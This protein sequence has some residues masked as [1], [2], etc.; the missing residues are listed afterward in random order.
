MKSHTNTRPRMKELQL[1]PSFLQCILITLIFLAPLL[2]FAKQ[3]PSSTYRI[4][5]PPKPD[6]SSVEWMLGNWTGQMDRHSPQG[7]IHLSVGYDLDRQVMV[8]R[9]KISLAATGELPAN[10]ESSIGIL[11]RAPSGDSFLF[12]VYST[13]GFI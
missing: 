3:K 7:E 9:E 4:P 5:L 10:N 13:T 11:S 1:N 8:F 6:F 12:E 2:M